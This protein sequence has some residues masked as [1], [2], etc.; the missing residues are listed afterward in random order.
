MLSDGMSLSCLLQITNRIFIQTAVTG[1][2]CNPQGIKTAYKIF[3]CTWLPGQKSCFS[4]GKHIFPEYLHSEFQ[5]TF[6]STMQLPEHRA[7][8]R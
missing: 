2:F 6:M 5:L 4:S 3:H 8:I 1:T 7:L